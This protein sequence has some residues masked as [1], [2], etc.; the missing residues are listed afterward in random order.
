MNSPFK[1]DFATRQ[2]KR[3]NFRPKRWDYRT[4]YV[5]VAARTP[6]SIVQHGIFILKWVAIA[7]VLACISV[8]LSPR[9]YTAEGD[10]Y[11]IANDQSVRLAVPNH[12][13]T[14]PKRF[15]IFGPSIL[16]ALLAGIGYTVWCDRREVE[17]KQT[18]DYLAPSQ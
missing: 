7:F 3:S 1:V 2:K 13:P 8:P 17:S 16:S 14:S 4:H 5:D 10:Q 18:F 9:S 12:T 11:E 6:S 15:V